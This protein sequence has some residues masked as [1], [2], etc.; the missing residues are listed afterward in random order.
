MP[1]RNGS[2]AGTAASGQGRCSR[3]LVVVTLG[4]NALSS[5]WSSPN[6]HQASL[7]H[8]SHIRSVPWVPDLWGKGGS[9]LWRP[10]QGDEGVSSDGQRWRSPLGT[11]RECSLSPWPCFLR[12][13]KTSAGTC[14]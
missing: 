10:L 7:T 11:T 14:T 3:G 13:T 12:V 9:E 1:H 2:S 4:T 8:V 6:W 5:S